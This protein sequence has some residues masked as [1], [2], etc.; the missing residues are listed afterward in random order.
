LKY[1]K[2]LISILSLPIIAS[3]ILLILSMTIPVPDI[4]PPTIALKV[5]S[6]STLSPTE[7]DAE[8]KLYTFNPVTGKP[9]PANVQVTIKKDNKI[10]KTA[11][12]R[13]S[14]DGLLK[15]KLI[16]D[17]GITDKGEY[18]LVIATREDKVR[19]PIV[20]VDEPPYYIMVM[21]DKAWY[22]PGQVVH[23]RA[24][25]F[26]GLGRLIPVS[27]VNVTFS[28][29]SPKG[30]KIY[31]RTLSTNNYGVATVNIPLANELEH[32]RYKLRI[33]S[34]NVTRELVLTI[35][36]YKLPKMKIEIITDKEWYLPSEE[37]NGLINA[38]YTF[39]KPVAN[40]T[41]RL[42]IVGYVG[43][44]KELAEVTLKTNNKGIAYFH[45]EAPRYLVGTG[46]YRGLSKI[47]LNVTIEDNA[48]N[49]ETSIK[50]LMVS[51]Q[52]MIINIFTPKITLTEE[53][54]PITVQA[55]YPDGRIVRE[56]KV[57]VNVNSY[58]N[59][60]REVPILSLTGN[61]ING[62]FT[63]KVKP[64]KN[65]TWIRIEVTVID[66]KGYHVK[67]V[68][69]L[70]R[71]SKRNEPNII[72]MLSNYT[73]RV[74]DKVTALAKIT[75][76]NK[77][78]SGWVYF[79][80]INPV[81]RITLLT[82]A[83]L[84][85]NGEAKLSFQ[86][87]DIFL[88]YVI[89][90]AYII[91]Q[92]TEVIS[93]WARLN[94]EPSEDLRIRIH[95]NKKTYLPGENATITI[96]IEDEKGN[97]IEA[98]VGL[99]IIDEALYHLSKN[100]LGFEE[101]F[102]ELE[103]EYQKP[104][105]EVHGLPPSGKVKVIEGP[106]EYNIYSLNVRKA[107]E[108]IIL[109][110]HRR[111]FL[112]ALAFM[113]F[114]ASP[115]ASGILLLTYRRY[116]ALGILLLTFST[117]ILMTSN[118]VLYSLSE[119]ALPY[120]VEESVVELEKPKVKYITVKPRRPQ[121]FWD[122]AGVLETFRGGYAVKTVTLT[123]TTTTPAPR[124]TG[125]SK[126]MEEAIKSISVRWFFPETLYWSPQLIVNGSLE[127]TIPLAH[128]ITTW[129]IRA[130]AHTMDGRIAWGSG[131][132]TVFKEFFIE[133]DIPLKMTQ[134]DEVSI[135]VAIY[136]YIEKALNITLVLARESWFKPLEP[137]V[138]NITIPANSV[139]KVY[140]RIKALEPGVHTITVYAIAGNYTDAVKKEV[141][142]LA[143]GVPLEYSK[144]GK[145][146][147][148]VLFNLKVFNETSEQSIIA[149]LKLTLGYGAP[150]IEGFEA[151]VGYPWGCVEQTSSRLIPCTLV[152]KYLT[153]TDQLTP[154]MRAKLDS[155]I[156]TGIQRL[157]YL[158]HADGSFG[159]WKNDPP[160]T[161]MSAWVLNTWSEI[162]NAGFYIDQI[163]VEKLK[164]WLLEHQ[165]NDGSWEPSGW[166]GHGRYKPTKIVMTAYVLRSLLKAG[167]S[168][169]EEH[170][171]KGVECL[172]EHLK[173]REPK[174]PYEVALSLIAFYYAKQSR[175]NLVN[176]LI[177]WLK[178]NAKT[179]DK[180]IYWSGG[181]SFAGPTETTAYAATALL[182]WNEDVELVQSALSWLISQRGPWG[183]L[184]TTSDT[185]AFLKLLSLIA[186]KTKEI[187][188]GEVRVYVNGRLVYRDRITKDNA[189]VVRIVSLKEHLT[190][191]DNTVKVE[192]TVKPL[193]YNLYFH[194]TLRVELKATVT[195]DK[196]NVKKGE[197]VRATVTLTPP[198]SKVKPVLIKVYP[199]ETKG[200]KVIGGRVRAINILDRKEKVTFY[201]KAVEPGEHI[202][203][204]FM[205]EYTLMYGSNIGGL[206]VTETEPLRITVSTEAVETGKYKVNIEKHLET[207]TGL[208][209]IAQ[210]TPI[211]ITITIRNLDMKTLRNIV[212]EDP[213]PLGCKVQ[214]ETLPSLTW[215]QSGIVRKIQGD[216]VVF[217][218]GEVKPGE[219]ITLNYIIIPVVKGEIVVPGAILKTG[220]II[221][222]ATEPTTLRVVEKG[223]SISRELDTTALEVN[224][225]A[226]VIV[227]LF[228]AGGYGRIQWVIVDI[229]IPPGFTFIK[230]TL[231]QVV[232]ENKKITRYDIPEVRRVAFFIEYM[233]P[234][235]TL[236]FKF[237]IK[238]LMPVKAVIQPAQAESMYTTEAKAQSLPQLIQVD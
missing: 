221:I 16:S 201:L 46:I 210:N 169:T 15:L 115:L 110:K 214:L 38:S 40:A 116:K 32:G 92:G 231:D 164:K 28:L 3:L 151:L 228:Y 197:T 109:V 89:V 5:I 162:L 91:T 13:S 42:S 71:Y 234:G 166:F 142:V 171:V 206:I 59:K 90:R 187:N 226:W 135:R 213:I 121:I 44:Y 168:P 176:K 80:I 183:G 212:V 230:E 158:Q 87:Y 107:K 148:G 227:E 144:S 146:D 117:A 83:V 236:T 93:D 26:K 190:R 181:S 145:M 160:N 172:R 141:K 56:G 127:L 147:K 8:L 14:E 200:F 66:N 216:K 100:M 238:A 120:P 136:N 163:A 132:I 237:K 205:V 150:L 202:I 159:W 185:A 157:L 220:N 41:A 34:C 170:I 153:S 29:I 192:S 27:N 68:T 43:K 24:I 67:Q 224:D 10:I 174:D 219:A 57:I 79:D 235:E 36:E 178:D 30:T 72:L 103:K 88:P 184:K 62:L 139:S 209:I 75:L 98:I 156:Q 6:P 195:L 129:H 77:V 229:P 31:K 97:P 25:V 17:L 193:H 33:E 125:I 106:K 112:Q 130:L 223:L 222:N 50:E 232:E 104:M 63:F 105:Y 124:T 215:N 78:Y 85:E 175:D 111:E 95:T 73:V 131:G 84:A 118:I 23:A 35:E 47:L 165:C 177:K 2:A 218:V 186:E 225:E 189:D 61:L 182:L 99:A 114:S 155:Y 22:Q 60:G 167:V 199:V 161:A 194:Q 179:S 138:K 101:T 11:N 82:K 207:V 134:D 123:A 58:D 119:K 55:K 70:Y 217:M 74:G 154:E 37:I 64:L 180:G 196:N 211:H 21:T 65:T 81:T 48:G 140:W 49:I 19:I 9:V 52:P 133:P 12:L 113:T 208:D 18:E 51:N 173:D 1:N 96:I 54:I 152:W 191:G 69:S 188:E 122:L 4:K 149:Y 128:S 86:V 94:V 233:D 39:G 108:Y 20:M 53:E 7:A 204:P 126:G 45:L 102:Y 203:G 76:P 137:L 198:D 143:N